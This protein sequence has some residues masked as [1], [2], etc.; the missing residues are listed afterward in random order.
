MFARICGFFDSISFD[1]VEA[2]IYTTRHKYL[3]DSFQIMTSAGMAGH[4]RDMISYI[5]HELPMWLKR[6]DTPAP[7][8]SRV[9]RLLK[10]FPITPDVKV[11][12]DERGQYYY[13]NIV[14]GD[15]P[16][17]LYRIARVLARYGISIYTAKINTLGERAEDTLLV[18]GDALKNSRTVVKLETDLVS[19][20]Q[21][22]A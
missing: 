16:G 14:A 11:R 1:I 21:D 19:E 12:P 2:K 6:P 10:N 4:Y 22:N 17:L 13:L 20:M 8:K 18:T 7:P 3:L 5:E 9:S 15:R